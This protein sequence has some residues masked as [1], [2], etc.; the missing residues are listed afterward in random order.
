[1]SITSKTK[2]IFIYTLLLLIF[3]STV[4]YTCYKNISEETPEKDAGEYLL[5]AYNLQ[6]YKTLSLE[7]GDI[8]N[9]EPTAYREPVFPAYLALCIFLNPTT[10]E[11]GREELF[12]GGIRYLKFMQIPIL[13]IISLIA[14]YAVYIFTKNLTISFITMFLI[15]ISISLEGTIFKLLSENISALLIILNSL[16]LF[17]LLTQKKIILFILLGFTSGILVLDKA[18]FQY[19]IIL[20]L[21][22]LVV[23]YL[24]TKFVAKKV[25]ITGFLLLLLINSSIIGSYMIRNYQQFNNSN[26]TGRGGIVL[27]IRAEKDNMTLKEYAASLLYWTPSEKI[28]T[29]LMQKIF[30]E[31][32]YRRLIRSNNDSFYYKVTREELGAKND[33]VT[34]TILPEYTSFEKDEELKNKAIKM[35]LKNP[36]RHVIATVQFVW[37]GIFVE[38]GFLLILPGSTKI[39]ILNNNLLNL[40]LFFSFFYMFIYSIR[41][42]MWHLF[43]FMM[44]GIYLFSINSFIT[45]NIPRY[46]IPIIPVL[47]ISMILFFYCRYRSG[48]ESVSIIKQ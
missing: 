38:K 30:S 13:I 12:T 47:I 6:K 46:N 26:L 39:E 32:D 23:Y 5:M 27:L 18:I 3:I 43:A 9:P 45:H 33:T 48:K 19:F 15:G 8:E 11:M 42:R 21:I 14:F 25:F 24:K 35:I 4:F 2:K 28:N 31:S 37:R 7:P 34:N 10:R 29:L 20:L 22:F 36:F 17:K 1:M 16:L 41:K 40:F 44:P